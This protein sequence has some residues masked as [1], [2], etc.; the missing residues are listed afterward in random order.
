MRLAT[1]L[2]IVVSVLLIAVSTISGAF[3]IYTNQSAQVST[4]DEVLKL[5]VSEIKS[6]DEDPFSYSLVVAENSTIPMTLAYITNSESLSYLTENAGTLEV[7]PSMQRIKAG[8]QSPI[9]LGNFRAQFLSINKS[10]TL[11]LLLSTK[12]IDVAISKTWRQIL[13]FDVLIILAGTLFVFIFFRRDSKINANARAMQEFIGDA[14]HELKTPLTVIRGYSELLMKESEKAER[15]HS[16]SLRMSRI[17]DDLLTI[18]ALD[19]GLNGEIIQVDISNLLQREIDD[20]GQLQSQRTIE[21]I[22]APCVIQ[23][24][25]RII[26][27]LISNIFANIKAHTPAGAPVRVQSNNHEF[28]IEDGGPGLKSL[29]TKPFQRF[30]ASR[31]R[32]TGGSGL[33]M[34]IIEKS[35]RHLGGKV[36]FSKSN[37]GGL[38]I[39]VRFK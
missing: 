32:E 6:S 33:G 7:K 14:S 31:S 37:L 10:E 9:K 17:I 12:N 39:T 11:G 26:Q 3:A 28:S 22:I 2:S 1:R 16:E 18:A 24:E 36:Q 27:T 38:K 4:Y 13:G 29:P 20:L 5:A 30:D 23:G 25:E 15:I 34:S 19:E 8:E 35:A 21:A